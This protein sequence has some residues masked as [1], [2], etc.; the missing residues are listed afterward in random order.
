MGMLNHDDLNLTNKKRLN[1]GTKIVVNNQV[2]REE[3]VKMPND[4]KHTFPV[5]V[6]VDNHIRN[7]ISAL[8]NLGTAKSQK[9]L[10]KQLVEN[11][12][13]E[14]S[15]SDKKRFT[16]MFEILEEKDNLKQ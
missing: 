3:L 2:N 11:K 10:V 16:R 4:L 8:L 9:G 15:D 7:Q 13:D 5:N 14:L 12:I 1:R 6:R